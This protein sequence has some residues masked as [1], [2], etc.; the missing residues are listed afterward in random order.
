[1]SRVNKV[2]LGTDAILS[3]GALVAASGTKLVAKAAKAHQVPLVVL[4]GTYKLSP[5][6]PYDPD[7]YVEYGD[8]AKVLPYEDG[9][10]RELGVEVENPLLE[11]VAGEYVDLYVTNLG[12][13][14]PSYLYR[15]VRDQ[16]R[17]EDVGF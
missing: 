9:E 12:A 13:H 14:A 3:N 10:L 17:D 4:S 15:V 2:I 16:Y 6:Y 5:R 11:F 8:V 7:V 1:M